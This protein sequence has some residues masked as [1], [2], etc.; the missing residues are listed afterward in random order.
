MKECSVNGCG[1]RSESKGYCV[2]HYQIWRRHG[3]ATKARYRVG[4]S[5]AERFAQYCKQGPGCWEWSGYR[6]PNGYGRLNIRQPNKT[7]VPKLAHRISWELFRGPITTEQHVCHKCDNPCCVNPEHLFVGDPA[8]NS[9]DKIAKGR[10]RYGVS[11]GVDHGGSKLTEDQVREIRASVG[12]SHLTAE[13]YGVSG[14]QVRDIRNL[15]SWR[16]LP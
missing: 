5:V 16:H 8:A 10:M 11:Q 2:R 1:E 7:Y 14:R 4:L 9:D 6:D 15:K 3:D 13:K 12:A